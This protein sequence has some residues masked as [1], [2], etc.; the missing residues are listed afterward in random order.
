M[1]KQELVGHLNVYLVILVHYEWSWGRPLS[2]GTYSYFKI[3]ALPHIFHWTRLECSAGQI[4]SPGPM[5]DTV[6]F[7][8]IFFTYLS[9][10]VNK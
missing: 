3:Y 2:A 5:F 9:T 10:D 8:E 4:W 1:K 7:K 6:C